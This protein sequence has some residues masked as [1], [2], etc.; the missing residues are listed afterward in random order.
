MRLAFDKIDPELVRELVEVIA[1][2]ELEKI[3][4]FAWL[5]IALM[6]IVEVPKDL[7]VPELVSEFEFRVVVP[8]LWKFPEFVIELL[9]V[10]LAA[11]V[12]TLRFAPAKILAVLLLI[13]LLAVI[14]KS[15]D[16][17]N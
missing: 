9:F 15:E 7:I 8:A 5:V 3:T 13:R 14:V 17:L 2:S 11:L 16:E 4:A 12:L 6:L 10:L 1:A